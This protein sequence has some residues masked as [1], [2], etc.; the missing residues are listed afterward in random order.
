MKFPIG[1]RANILRWMHRWEVSL[2]LTPAWQALVFSMSAMFSL[3]CSLKGR[4]L[5]NVG[6]YVAINAELGGRVLCADIDLSLGWC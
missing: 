1:L 5:S 6:W 2:A 4:V 3:M